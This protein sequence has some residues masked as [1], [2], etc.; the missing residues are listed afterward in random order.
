MP[1]IQTENHSVSSPNRFLRQTVSIVTL[2]MT[3]HYS[4]RRAHRVQE[5]VSQH[6][7]SSQYPLTTPS[8]CFE[9]SVTV[10]LGESAQ[11]SG[12]DCYDLGFPF[13][14]EGWFNHENVE[15]PVIEATDFVDS[16]RSTTRPL[17]DVNALS[18]SAQIY[19]NTEWPDPSMQY[20]G[21]WTPSLSAQYLDR[22][23]TSQVM[24]CRTPDRRSNSPT[25]FRNPETIPDVH[26]RRG[27]SVS[28]NN[29]IGN[30]IPSHVPQRH[31]VSNEQRF[32]RP[33]LSGPSTS[34][35]KQSSIASTSHAYT[36]TWDQS[37]GCG[38]GRSIHQAD[39]RSSL[40]SRRGS[41]YS[42]NSSASTIDNSLIPSSS[43]STTS[44]PSR[45]RSY[46]S[47]SRLS[48]FQSSFD[49]LSLKDI[50]P[51]QRKRRKT[52]TADQ[53]H[54]RQLIRNL[55]GACEKCKNTKRQVRESVRC[56][57]LC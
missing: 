57:L 33:V 38:R 4:N 54:N 48:P 45:H 37:V 32:A 5:H 55:G 46:N 6:I 12:P 53:A 39:P 1:A 34:H 10:G 8:Y 9:Q 19:T 42:I 30:Q 25:L 7:D 56:L 15:D 24:L 51:Q 49:S 35:L 47:S 44:A 18:S 43:L 40:S 27:E 36:L 23:E 52:P 20:V 13:L 31:Q 26:S 41:S 11:S 29:R 50:E 14:I 2:I 22:H 17:Y 16:T 28:L 3:G 21:S